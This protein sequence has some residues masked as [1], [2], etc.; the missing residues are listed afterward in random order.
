MQSAEVSAF[1][2]EEM[3]EDEGTMEKAAVQNEILSR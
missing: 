3:K 2:D 1:D